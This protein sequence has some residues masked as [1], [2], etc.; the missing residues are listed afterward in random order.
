MSEYPGRLYHKTPGW[1]S[2][3]VSFHIRIRAAPSQSSLLDT[4]LGP[5]LLQAAQRYHESGTWWCELFLLMPDH[6]HAILAF[7]ATPGMSETVRNWKRATSRFHHVQW[8]EGFFD[9]RL[10]SDS[11]ARD[12]WDYIRRNPVV[13][14]LCASEEDW[15]WWWSGVLT[16]PLAPL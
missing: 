2:E 9:H 14:K 6:A 1:V 5:A 13:T 12:K 11:E 10:R 7:P 15:P 8:Q 4:A 3:G 16:N